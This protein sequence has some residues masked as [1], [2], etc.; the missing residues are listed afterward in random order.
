MII[1]GNVQMKMKGIAFKT[2]LFTGGL[3]AAVALLIYAA[4]YF[5]MPDFY[6][7]EKKAGVESSADRLTAQLEGKRIGEIEGLLNQYSLKN[8]IGVMILDES[9]QLVYAPPA[10]LITSPEDGGIP[11]PRLLTKVELKLDR[12]R[13]GEI[14]GLLETRRKTALSDGT[15]EL[16]ITAPLQPISE[17]AGILLKMLPYMLA[18]I[19]AI[20]AAGALVYSKIITRPILYISGVAG[21][22][23]RM[24]KGAEVT[25]GA[26]DEI[27]LLSDNL[28]LLYGNLSQ[29]IDELRASNEKLVAEM[30][31]VRELERLKS[32]FMAAASHEFKTPLAAVSGILEG[33]LDNIGVYKDRDK[34]LRECRKLMGSLSGLVHDVLELSRLERKDFQT[35]LTNLNLGRILQQTL[36]PYRLIAQAKGVNLCLE[37][38]FDFEVRA[39]E[40]LLEKALSNVLSNALHYTLAGGK[41]R[42]YAAEDSLGN[43]VPDA[44]PD[45]P[46]RL[47]VENEGENIREDQIKD[48]FEPF[49]RGD[50]SRSRA[51]GGSGLGLYIVRTSLEACGVGYELSNIRG[52]V[53][54]VFI[55]DNHLEAP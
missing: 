16:V 42:I 34:Y 29:A 20:A 14:T 6:Y 26:R 55:F 50:S 46:L 45:G 31:H 44:R 33:M 12:D 25:Y 2:F 1:Q 3:L 47:Y 51:T 17:A 27:G 24:E 41:V 32:D 40:K 18:A 7:Q 43:M 49:S 38:P 21:K 10:I 39:D 28:N 8:N 22:M 23:A 5:I 11:A 36:E 37:G 54:F 4:L 52:G 9:G 15:Y 19:L 53:R 13:A 48:L 30:E 35:G